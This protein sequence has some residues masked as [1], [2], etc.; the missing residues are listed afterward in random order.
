[1]CFKELT[2]IE[3]E[4]LPNDAKLERGTAVTVITRGES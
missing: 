3:V 2:D 4:G 1:M